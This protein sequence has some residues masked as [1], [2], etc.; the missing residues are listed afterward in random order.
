MRYL[1]LGAHDG[2]EIYWDSRE[3]KYVKLR[4]HGNKTGRWKN[5]LLVVICVMII[6]GLVF[7]RSDHGKVI[8]WAV[9]PPQ[10]E[11][12]AFVIGVTMGFLMVKLGFGESGSVFRE[13]G[14]AT[15]YEA[16]MAV[17]NRG[18]GPL[19][20]AMGH[21]V[22][23]CMHM[24]IYI[25]LMIIAAFW[26]SLVAYG[27]FWKPW[28]QFLLFYLPLADVIILFLLVLVSA[29]IPHSDRATDRL[30]SGRSNEGRHS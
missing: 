17:R 29:V 22:I 15:P 26:D 9:L 27:L 16:M 12:A 6:I 20:M 25:V 21:P 4:V 1:R 18:N 28:V 8:R 14:D 24:Y 5:W 30:L 7:A 3:E 2:D 19:L 11:V 23:H 13:L 10:W